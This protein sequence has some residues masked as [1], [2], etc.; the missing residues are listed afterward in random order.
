MTD[1]SRF[2]P[3]AGPLDKIQHLK[4]LTGA[5]LDG[6]AV[7]IPNA[8]GQLKIRFENLTSGF[9]CEFFCEGGL[10]GQSPDVRNNWYVT[11]RDIYPSTTTVTKNGDNDYTITTPAGTDN[12]SYQFVFNQYKNVAP[13]MQR[14]AGSNLAGSNIQVT[15]TQWRYKPIA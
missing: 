12:R 2:F 1:G 8:N 15:V 4:V 10:G 9:M 3:S 14:T 13:T 6:G 7:S 5:S 11:D